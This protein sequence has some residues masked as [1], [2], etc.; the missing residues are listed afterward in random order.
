MKHLV[1]FLTLAGLF[2]S[3]ETGKRDTVELS[4]EERATVFLAAGYGEVFVSFH[5]GVGMSLPLNS[6]DPNVFSHSHGVIG[7]PF[8]TDGII[9]GFIPSF[10]DDSQDRNFLWNIQGQ[11]NNGKMAISFPAV[12]HELSLEYESDF[13]E[14]ARIAEVLISAN[15][16]MCVDYE[17]RK[18]IEI[19]TVDFGNYEHNSHRVHIHYADKDF[20][21]FNNGKVSLKTGWNFVES[22][23]VLYKDGRKDPFGYEVGLVSQDINDFYKS[24]YRWFYGNSLDGGDIPPQ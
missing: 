7:S 10:V 1:L 24:G 6:T 22:Y 8:R 17:L 14:G 20:N 2:I 5:N 18:L 13:T 12:E 4:A 19:D 23:T 21:K 15:G 16:S 11:V 9:D 3:C